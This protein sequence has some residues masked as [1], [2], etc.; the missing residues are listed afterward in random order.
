MRT[1]NWLVYE[2]LQNERA[3]RVVGSGDDDHENDSDNK[4]ENDEKARRGKQ[5]QQRRSDTNS[6]SLSLSQ[7][8][9][10]QQRR[11]AR[12][13]LSLSLRELCYWESAACMWERELASTICVPHNNTKIHVFVFWRSLAR[14]FWNF[15]VVCFIT[16]YTNIWHNY[17]THTHN[18]HKYVNVWMC[19][20]RIRTC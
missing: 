4:N 6:L 16:T 13:S 9:Q 11:P 12:L 10:Q 5:Q 20:E 17:F 1:D 15:F 3:R 18:L 19:V 2:A 7:Q 8:S 14:L